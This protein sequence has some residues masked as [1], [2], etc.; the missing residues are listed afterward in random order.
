MEKIPRLFRMVWNNFNSYCKYKSSIN[1]QLQSLIL[2]I[3]GASSLVPHSSTKLEAAPNLKRL[4]I[5]GKNFQTVSNGL[6]Y[7]QFVLQIQIKGKCAV[8]ECN[9]RNMGR[10][11]SGSA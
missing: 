8:T 4:A 11:K 1:L 3:W 7:F 2:E 10:F 9:A 6:E 5:N